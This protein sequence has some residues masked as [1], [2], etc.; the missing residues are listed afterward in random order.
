MLARTGFFY[1]R[2]VGKNGIGV[3]FPAPARA[4]FPDGGTGSYPNPHCASVVLEGSTSFHSQP[5]ASMMREM[6]CLMV[7]SSISSQSTTNSGGT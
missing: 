4:L 3:V 5:S 1:G 6:G 2:I 7:L